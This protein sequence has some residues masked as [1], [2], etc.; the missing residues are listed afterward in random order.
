M[1]SYCV[2]KL[3]AYIFVALAFYARFY[4]RILMSGH[5]FLWWNTA[6]VCHFICLLSIVIISTDGIPIMLIKCY[7]SFCY[8]ILFIVGIIIGVGI[9]GCSILL[10]SSLI[11]IL[12]ALAFH[13]RYR[14]NRRKH[15]GVGRQ[16]SALISLKRAKVPW[17][18]FLRSLI[19]FYLCTKTRF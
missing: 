9:S 1:F 19:F 12:V 17:I 5:F 4:V 13:A 14:R 8:Y 16:H 15:R 18:I 2:A 3:M 10:S 11:G 6:S 7:L